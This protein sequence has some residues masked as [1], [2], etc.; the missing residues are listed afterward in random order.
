M[1]NLVRLRCPGC[2]VDRKA[3]QLG[4]AADGHFDLDVAMP[5]ELSV[6]TDRFRGRG[7]IEVTREAVPVPLA[8]G[9]REML[10][11]R[12]AQVE[13]DIRAAGVELPDDD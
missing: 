9:V 1:A 4:L 13:A 5:N 12:L 2:G 6:R 10:K 7:R 11:H 8:L 3:E